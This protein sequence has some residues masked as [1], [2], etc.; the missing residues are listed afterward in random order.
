MP[1]LIAVA[2][3]A[4]LW[5]EPTTGISQYGRHLAEALS[6]RAVRV[7]RLGAARSGEAPRGRHLGKSAF[8]VGRLPQLLR[9]R[10]EVLFHAVGNFNLPLARIPGRRFVLTVHD[11]IPELFPETVSLAY[12]L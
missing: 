8:V 5:D 4:T 12:R 3:D 7:A 1:K 11:L 6:A 9:E 10:D 2:L